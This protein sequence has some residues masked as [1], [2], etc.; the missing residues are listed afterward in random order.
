MCVRLR[1]LL[2]IYMHSCLKSAKPL[3]GEGGACISIF[4]V[5][6]F[7]AFTPDVFV[8]VCQN[9]NSCLRIREATC[10]P[11]DRLL[12]EV[13][14]SVCLR[15]TYISTYIYTYIDIC[16]YI[17]MC[18]CIYMYVY[19][20]IY[21]FVASSSKYT[22]R[23]VYIQVHHS[24]C[25]HPCTLLGLSTYKN[26]ASCV[27]IQVDYQVC[28]RTSTP[29]GVS[30]KKYTTRCVYIEVHHSGSLHQSTILGVSTYKYTTRCVYID[31]PYSACLCRRVL[32][33]G[34]RL[35]CLSTSKGFRA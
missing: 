23:G 29:L 9:L 15:S 34:Y 28:L 1:C 25:I 7:I 27:Y 14:Y 26:T 6:V 18:I 12:I 17:C 30:T 32:D 10:R 13:H 3:V 33:L 22:T 21:I 5:Y 31:V 16:I 4:R 19:I 35:F 11:D 8:Y 24:V 2:H 20:Y